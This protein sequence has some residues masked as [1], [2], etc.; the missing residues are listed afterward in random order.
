MLHLLWLPFRIVFS[1]FEAVLGL[2]GGI[3]GAVFGLLG[4][5][6]SL[7]GNII[8]VLMI[9]GLILAAINL[10]KRYRRKKNVGFE[11]NDSEPFTSFYRER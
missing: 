5:I 9:S 2:V 7:I 11:S 1:V 10:R 6:V 3:I 8:A 4:G